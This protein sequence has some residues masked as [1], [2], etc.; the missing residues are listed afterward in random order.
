[1]SFV[2]DLIDGRDGFSRNMFYFDLY[3]RPNHLLDPNV[4]NQGKLGNC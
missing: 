3:T 1:M 4:I 2:K